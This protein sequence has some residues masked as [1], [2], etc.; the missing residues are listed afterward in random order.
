MVSRTFTSLGTA[1]AAGVAVLERGEAVVTLGGIPV[2]GKQHEPVKIAG[3]I[4]VPQS[5]RGARDLDN[6]LRP[7]P[8][9]RAA[10]CYCSSKRPKT[11]I[12][13]SHVLQRLRCRA[14]AGGYDAQRAAHR[15]RTYLSRRLRPT[16]LPMAE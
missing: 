16:V 9:H 15:V 10:P 7:R 13:R 8:E 14:D 5:C 3:T 12:K 6:R 11:A 1:L 2:H 4:R